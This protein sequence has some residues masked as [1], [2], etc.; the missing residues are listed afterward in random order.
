MKT[1]GIIGGMS[2]ESTITYYKTI[3]ETINN[4]L[5][6]LNSAKILLYSVNFEEIANL[7]KNGEWEKAAQILGECA[8]KLEL[9]GADFILIATNTMHKIFNQIQ[10]NI[11]IPLIHIAQST[12]KILKQQNI[13]TIGLLGTQYTMMEDFYKNA[14]KKEN[15]N[16]ITPNQSDMQELSDIIFNELCKGQMKENSKEK[17]LKIIQKLKDKGAQGIVL[18]CTEIGLLIS[19]EDTNIP[20]FDTALI[21]AL[22]AVNLA[23][24]D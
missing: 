6:N 17:Y 9:G 15:I 19:Q 20:I 5:G 2:F 12:A 11:K 7:Q 13:H 8:K 10:K 16:T 14:L 3:N 22:D 18:G 24:K 4:Q 1:I 23:L 21:H